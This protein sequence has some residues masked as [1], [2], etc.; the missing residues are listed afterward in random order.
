[1]LSQLP[2]WWKDQ[3]GVAAVEAAL[4]L[5]VLVTLTFGTISVGS[6][7]FV[8][9]NIHHAARETARTIAVGDG[10]VADAATIAN[11]YLL[12]WNGLSFTVI[13]TE[14]TAADV[15][16]AITVPMSEASL[17]DVLGIFSD[18]QLTSTVTFRK[19]VG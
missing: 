8:Q 12:G 17:V 13:G 19:E 7:L 16:V 18:G 14:P 15:N 6:I 4:I 2:R 11:T 10:E 1:M 3:K 9:N 5:P